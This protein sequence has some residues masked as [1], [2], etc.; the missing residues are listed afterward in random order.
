MQLIS[1]LKDKGLIYK[2]ELRK[3]G[4]KG[5][6]I[7]YRFKTTTDVAT[8]LVVQNENDEITKLKNEIAKL[9]QMLEEKN[10]APKKI[11]TRKSKV[12]KKKKV[13]Y[14][15]DVDISMLDFDDL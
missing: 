7:G 15:D 9:K 10:S 12:K 4:I 8:K 6:F 2:S 5:C 11:T 14:S 13:E 3:M 1:A